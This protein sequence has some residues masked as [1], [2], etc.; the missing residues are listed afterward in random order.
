M[1]KERLKSLQI[2]E[3]LKTHEMQRENLCKEQLEEAQYVKTLDWTIQDLET[4][5]KQLKN[6]KSCDP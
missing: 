2:K 6:N 3:E 1:Y 5:L 4:V